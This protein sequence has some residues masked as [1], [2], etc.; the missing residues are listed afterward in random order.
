VSHNDKHL[1]PASTAITAGRAAS[2]S[3]LAP[4]LWGSSVWQSTC[5]DD[6]NPR[7]TSMRPGQFYGRYAN[8]TVRS[9]EVA[10]A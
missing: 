1:K 8:P 3:S 5:M 10:I 4:A 9:F 7:A 2:G 6:A